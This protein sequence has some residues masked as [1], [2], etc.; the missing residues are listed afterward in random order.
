[1]EGVYVYVWRQAYWLEHPVELIAKATGQR[2]T[3][4]YITNPPRA[5]PLPIHAAAPNW[6]PLIMC[7]QQQPGMRTEAHAKSRGRSR[8]PENSRFSHT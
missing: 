8:G 5:A 2:L 1:M 3:R 4:D 6:V 7:A